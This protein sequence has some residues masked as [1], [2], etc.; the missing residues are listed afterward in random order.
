M[1]AGIE[2]PSVRQ[3][4]VVA[5]VG[6]QFVGP[7][8]FGGIADYGLNA[9]GGNAVVAVGGVEIMESVRGAEIQSV[10]LGRIPVEITAEYPV[11]YIIVA[12]GN[13][14]A[15]AAHLALHIFGVIPAAFQ[16]RKVTGVCGGE[17]T[18]ESVGETV[19]PAGRRHQIAPA[20]FVVVVLFV[21]VGII[22]VAALQEIF[23][24]IY[25]EMDIRTGRKT[26]SNL[27]VEIG[28]SIAEAQVLIEIGVVKAI[29]DGQ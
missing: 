7:V 10:C 25:H 19:V 6:V 3:A 2:L 28:E 13:I 12:V 15:L 1:K 29:V 16:S 9:V 22:L 11:V 24:V 17:L 21:A 18:R 23:A 8:A 20:Q 26:V 27:G 14:E 5:Y 4:P